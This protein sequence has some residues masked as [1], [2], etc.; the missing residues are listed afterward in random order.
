MK[1]E[2]FTTER[3]IANELRRRNTLKQN[4]AEYIRIDKIHAESKRN[5]PKVIKMELRIVCDHENE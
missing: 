3:T 1:S 4:D 5:Q 2:P